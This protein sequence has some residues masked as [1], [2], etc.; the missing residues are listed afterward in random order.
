M[1]VC[2]LNSFIEQ[3]SITFFQLP[4]ASKP[5]EIPLTPRNSHQFAS[6]W[7]KVAKYPDLAQSYLEVELS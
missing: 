4:E 1:S 5:K 6:D 7:Q 2:Y 3:F